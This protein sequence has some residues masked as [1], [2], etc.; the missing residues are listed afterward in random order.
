[1]DDEKRAE[2]EKVVQEELEKLKNISLEPDSDFIVLAAIVGKKELLTGRP[3]SREIIVAGE[4]SPDEVQLANTV[5][6]TDFFTEMKKHEFLPHPFELMP[7][8]KEIK[9]N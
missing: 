8:D 9:W 6:L 5:L 3:M 7:R 2:Y 1:M 4:A